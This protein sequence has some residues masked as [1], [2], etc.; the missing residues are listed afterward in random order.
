MLRS[1]QLKNFRGFSD[2]RLELEKQSILVG[3]NN[4][5]KTTIIEALRVLSVCQSR[6]QTTGFLPCP[7][8]LFPHC[9]GAGFRPALDVIDFDYANVQH[10]YNT[11]EP[12]IIIAKLTNN[13]E[14]HVFIG[15]DSSEVFCQLRR[16][17]REVV[18]DR[19]ATN[20]KLF[21]STKVM[22]PIGSLLPREKV[23][24]KDRLNRFLDGYLAY[25]HFRNQL[26][27]RPSDYRLFKELL[28]QTWGHL[29]IQHFE[30]DHGE[31]QNEFSLLVREGRFTSEISW[32]GHGLQA[33]MQT[34]WF[35]ARTS[36]SANIV[37]DEPDVYLHADL[38]RKLV[39]MIEGLKF[40]QAIIATHSPEII[41]DVPFQNV[42]VVQKRDQV[43]KAAE[44]AAA[45]QLSLRD[46]GSI[47]SVQLSKLATRGLI[48]FVE[49]EDRLLLGEVAYKLGAKVFDSFSEIAIH[50]IDGSGNWQRAIGAAKTLHQ[51][52]GGEV[53]SA[54]LIDRDY[55][56]P[57]EVDEMVVKASAN[58]LTLTVWHKKEIEN[59]FILPGPIARLCSARSARTVEEAEIEALISRI[60]HDMEEDLILSYVDKIRARDPRLS[61]KAA[62][63]KAKEYIATEISAGNSLQD[64]VSGKNLVSALSRECKSAYGASFNAL[65]ICKE[66]EI[67]EVP[68]EMKSYVAQLCK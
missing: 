67:A 28:E 18:H 50:E 64:M 52:S 14:I 6:A 2:H 27:E 48:L 15:K 47:H 44:R 62:Y 29:S 34:V 21:G 57:D 1:L 46:M 65:A 10:E 42:I 20:F 45:I 55:L 53:K 16:S 24:A 13:H 61:T 22:P 25:R 43:S 36:R 12:A 30:N 66:S 33:W 4:A 41:S 8:W 23:I 60:S 31:G 49:G 39:K 56:S 17:S 35:L 40:G 9:N 3:R 58:F 37:L 19:S 11:T 59:Y 63:K 32:H 51:A 54:L 26:W 68:E 5:G 38:Q 7:E